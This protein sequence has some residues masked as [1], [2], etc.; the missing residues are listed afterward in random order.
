MYLTFEL[1]DPR[2]HGKFRPT[3]KSLVQ[4]NTDQSVHDT[5]KDGFEA[6]SDSSDSAKTSLNILTKLKGIGPATASLLLSVYSPKTAPFFSDELFKWAFFQND[7]GKGWDRT[8]KYNVK[9]YL[10]LFENVDE[11]RR[12][13]SHEFDRDIAAVEI[14]KVAYV[15]GKRSKDPNAYPSSQIEVQSK[16]RKHPSDHS[17]S[18]GPVLPKSTTES[19]NV[20]PSKRVAPSK[21]NTSAQRAK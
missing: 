20:R 17:A 3:L 5:T 8:I 15:L 9:E 1:I 21:R 4:Q 10:E 14:E 12:R 7:N 16:K 18:E 6:F 2:S 19:A 11:L 13:F